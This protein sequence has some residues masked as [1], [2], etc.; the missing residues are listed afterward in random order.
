M[1]VGFQR[2]RI[3]L[4]IAVLAAVAVRFLTP[5]GWMPNPT[6]AG[7]SAIVICTADGPRIAKGLELPNPGRGH[8]TGHDHCLFAGFSLVAGPD[9]AA[10]P[11]PPVRFAADSGGPVLHWAPRLSGERHRP[12]F[13][14]GPPQ[15]V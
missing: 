15:L 7:G 2:W 13:P 14:R 6:G 4:V 5:V 3:G 10:V 11:T 12:Q 1:R 9:L 8:D